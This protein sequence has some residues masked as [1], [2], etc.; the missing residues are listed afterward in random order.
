[1]TTRVTSEASQNPTD[2]AIERHI[3]PDGDWHHETCRCGA[4][5]P[6]DAGILARSLSTALEQLDF[7]NHRANAALARAE[8]AERVVEQARQ[9]KAIDRELP[10]G[11]SS[12]FWH[13]LAD[14]YELLDASTPASG[15]VLSVGEGEP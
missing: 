11:A 4:A 5:H 13:A 1:M 12:E 7:H 8:A 9:L 6:C 14:M 3:W 15:V 2:A 10:T